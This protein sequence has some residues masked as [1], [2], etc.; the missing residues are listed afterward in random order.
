MRGCEVGNK[1]HH[2]PAARIR[3][4]CAGIRIWAQVCAAILDM[5]VGLRQILGLGR[6][7]FAIL[8]PDEYCLNHLVKLMPEVGMEAA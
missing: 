5:G 4:D 1:G 2:S 8:A 7:K 3:P 6:R